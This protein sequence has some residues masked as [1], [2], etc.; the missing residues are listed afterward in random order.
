MY[1]A[2]ITRMYTGLDVDI[3][4]VVADNF[5]A[6]SVELSVS[7]IDGTPI[8]GLESNNFLVTEKGYPVKDSKLVY[9]GNMS[10]VTNVAVLF[11][12]SEKMNGKNEYRL[13]VLREIFKAQEGKGTIS[14]I[15]AEENPVMEIKNRLLRR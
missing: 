1:L 8:V 7:A 15:S 11:E 12:G 9:S 14:V 3:E 5:P 10:G 2:D 4:K 13:S 6:V